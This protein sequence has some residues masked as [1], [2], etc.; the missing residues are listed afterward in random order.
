MLRNVPV[1][2]RSTLRLAVLVLAL[3]VHV[4]FVAGVHPNVDGAG[5]IA[6]EAHLLGVGSMAQR[7]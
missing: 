3:V 7:V 6:H 5:I 2:K 1:H 4:R